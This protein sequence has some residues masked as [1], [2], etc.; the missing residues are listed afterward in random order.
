MVILVDT[1]ILIDYFRQ[2]DKQL[3]IFHKTFK[4]NGNLSAAIC[5]TTVSELWSGDSMGDKNNRALT[6]Q[7][8][9]S[10]SIIKNNMKTAK[11]TGEL[12]REK[13]D[14]ISFPDAEIAACALYHKL[15]LLTLNQ[16]DFRK[17]K[18]IK[19]LPI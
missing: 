15:P 3:T 19:L 6:E 7:F 13:K 1:N 10:I 18:G 17:I 8:L 12:I 5:L 4:S 9:S 11:I 14:G 2:K 16:K